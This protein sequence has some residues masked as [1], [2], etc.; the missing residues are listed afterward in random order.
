[1]AQTLPT[2]EPAF[3]RTG[4]TLAWRRSLADYPAQDWVLKYRL[5][6]AAG[7]IDLTATADGSDH[8]ISVAAATSAAWAAG[9]YE[10][11]SYVEGGTAERY[12]VGTGRLTLRPNLAAQ[13]GGFEARSTARKA[14]AD[15]RAALAT[16]IST[17]GQVQEYEIAGRRMKYASAGDIR[18]RISLLEREVAREDTAEKLAAGQDPGRR[19]LV[20]F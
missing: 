4:D 6:N 18:A 11:Q 1:M 8:L 19:L 10:W 5:I 3:A 20:R 9:E 17:S 15:L 7:K 2:T 14:L 16:W 13:A 12:T